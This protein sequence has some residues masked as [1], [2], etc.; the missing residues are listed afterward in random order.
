MSGRPKRVTKAPFGPDGVLVSVPV[1]QTRKRALT[2]ATETPS[3]AKKASLTPVQPPQSITKLSTPLSTAIEPSPAPTLLQTPAAKPT[4]SKPPT[5]LPLPTS[6][7]AANKEQA[8][9]DQLDMEQALPRAVANFTASSRQPLESHLRF[10]PGYTIDP[11]SSTQ[12]REKVAKAAKGIVSVPANVG[13]RQM[14]LGKVSSMP[15]AQIFDLINSFFNVRYVPAEASSYVLLST[16]RAAFQSLCKDSASPE[17]LQKMDTAAMTKKLK[18]VF[19]SA[20]EH[21]KGDFVFTYVCISFSQ[22]GS[23]QLLPV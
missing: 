12:F 15:S 9:K 5:V 20:W 23:V 14:N 3:S 4:P 8:A 7:T 19:F 2:P 18:F 10:R 16:A 13:P 21:S 1:V 17:Y 6:T 22:I 11:A